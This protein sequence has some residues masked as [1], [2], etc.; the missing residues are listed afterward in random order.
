MRP[1]LVVTWDMWA[2]TPVPHGIFSTSI[3]G[4][5]IP[6][7][8][9]RWLLDRRKPETVASAQSRIAVTAVSVMSYISTMLL[10]ITRAR[11]LGRAV[12]A[13]SLCETE[14]FSVVGGRLSLIFLCNPATVSKA[15]AN[16]RHT[17]KGPILRGSV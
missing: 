1:P 17:E 3:Y 13:E 15:V 5:L 4:E 16:T 11:M 7:E 2:A 8:A 14:A 6:C 10:R 12:V 9:V